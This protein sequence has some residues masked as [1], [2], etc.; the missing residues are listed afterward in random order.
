MD[1]ICRLSDDQKT[2]LQRCRDTATFTRFLMD[3]IEDLRK[4]VPI[5][6]QINIA[7]DDMMR[8]N[9]SLKLR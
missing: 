9:E 1:R 6:L 5:P 3:R 7:L 2:K 4:E 8:E